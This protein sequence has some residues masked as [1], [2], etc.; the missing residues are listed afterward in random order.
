M[1]EKQKTNEFGRKLEAAITAI[2]AHSQYLASRYGT[3][4]EAGSEPSLWKPYHT[5]ERELVLK[6]LPR[7]FNTAIVR[8]NDPTLDSSTREM[9]GNLRQEDLP[10]MLMAASFFYPSFEDLDTAS[11]SLAKEKME[12]SGAFSKRDFAIVSAVIEA[13]VVK[14]SHDAPVKASSVDQQSSF[15]GHGMLLSD[16]FKVIIKG[17]AESMYL[18]PL[19]GIERL[20]ESNA[21]KTKNNRLP[22]NLDEV[23]ADGTTYSHDVL[24][25]DVRRIDRDLFSAESTFNPRL[26]ITTQKF[27]YFA[28]N[29][30]Y[31]YNT[32]LPQ[33]EQNTDLSSMLRNTQQFALDLRGIGK[34]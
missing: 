27:P 18:I 19:L 7:L 13:A 17:L 22:K 6:I 8:K 24:R 21:I 15:A 34:H 16:T 5:L 2:D 23:V 26:S 28:S 10:A 12:E 14:E 1:V 4:I 11:P 9:F 20:V 32:L 30:E 31:F 25:N 33:S 29:K 3:G